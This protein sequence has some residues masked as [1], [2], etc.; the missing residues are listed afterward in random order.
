MKKEKSA[1]NI[2]GGTYI[3]NLHMT[4]LLHCRYVGYLLGID[5]SLIPKTCQEAAST[6]HAIKNHQLSDPDEDSIR[7][8]NSLFDQL[9]LHPT[10]LFVHRSMWHIMCRFKKFAIIDKNS[11]S[12]QQIFGR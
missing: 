9:H 4:S 2:F 8:V 7:L 10:Y 12:S 11:F 6:M 1:I 5:E 3:I